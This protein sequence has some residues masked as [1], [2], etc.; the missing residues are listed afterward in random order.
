MFRLLKLK[1]PHGWSAVA[2]ELGIV[3]IGVL[4]ALAAQQIVQDIHDRAAVTQLRGALR[5]ELADD[6][7]RWEDMRASDPCTVQR[8]AMLDQWATTAPAQAKLVR[9]FVLRL[10][11]MHS[12]A[13]DVAKTSA[14]TGNLPLDERLTYAE[15]YG[16]IDNWRE[17]FAEERAETIELSALL[18]NADEP[19]SR[20]QVKFQI[21]KER[22]LVRRRAENY[23]YFF[24]RFDALKIRPDWSQLTTIAHDPKALCKPLQQVG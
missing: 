8:L 19:D 13:W 15:L 9:P 7:A 2:W 12:S 20:R 24:K 17:Y 23:A 6:R 18:E 14:A 21:A 16:A 10:W 5:A 1:P 22:V 4:I 11:N 3:T